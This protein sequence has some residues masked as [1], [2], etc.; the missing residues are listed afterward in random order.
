MTSLSCVKVKS[1]INLCSLGER[2]VLHGGLYFSCFPVGWMGYSAS[3]NLM[4]WKVIPCHH[5]AAK[6]KAQEDSL[7][8]TSE[9]TTF[10]FLSIL[11]RSTSAAQS[12][13]LG[14]DLF[15]FQHHYR[16]PRVWQ[17]RQT[18]TL[19]KELKRCMCLNGHFG[20]RCTG[21]IFTWAH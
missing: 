1:V 8:N 10:E 11:I 20:S 2:H 17:Q 9:K 5:L 7:Y 3:N 13:L 18:T 14:E 15:S 19:Y 21:Q 6:L 16:L 12:G 4:Y